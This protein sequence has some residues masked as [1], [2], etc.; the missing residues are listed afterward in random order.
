MNFLQTQ[1]NNYTTTQQQ[2]AQQFHDAVAG[3]LTGAAAQLFEKF[4]M[5]ILY[6]PNIIW[7]LLTHKHFDRS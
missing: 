4:W 7:Y 6:H 3:N 1:Y 5:R 2:R